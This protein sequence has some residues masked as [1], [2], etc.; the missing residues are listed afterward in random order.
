MNCTY[1]YIKFDLNCSMFKNM[2]RAHVTLFKGTW[3]RPH[4]ALLAFSKGHG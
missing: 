1:V 4:V 3:L 2:T